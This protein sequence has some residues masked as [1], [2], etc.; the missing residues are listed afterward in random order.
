[1]VYNFMGNDHSNEFDT[2]D[3]ADNRVFAILAYIPILFWLPLACCN[4]SKFGRFHANQGLLLLITGVVLGIASAVISLILGW[5]PVL[6][7][8]I[9]GLVNLAVW[10]AEV[11]LLIYGMVN[12]GQ[13]KAKELPGIGCIAKLIE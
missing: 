6:G 2:Q 3:I 7:G 9:C 10:A 13:G 4:Q 11:G 1:M 5:I 12:A 8:I